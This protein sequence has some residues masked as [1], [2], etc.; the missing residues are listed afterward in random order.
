MSRVCS[1]CG[2]GA[3]AG[4]SRSHSNIA[5]KRKFSV[6]VQSKKVD[7]QRIKICTKCI[8]TKVKPAR[9]RVKKAA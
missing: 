9:V 1:V 5:T 2:R 8:K 6:N 3:K 4:N 7:G